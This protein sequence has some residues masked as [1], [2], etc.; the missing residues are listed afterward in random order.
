MDY[1]S[2]KR[3]IDAKRK[4]LGII[5]DEKNINKKYAVK[6]SNKFLNK[7]AKEDMLSKD[8]MEIPKQAQSRESILIDKAFK[9]W[10]D[11][12][13]TISPA[14]IAKDLGINAVTLFKTIENANCSKAL[15]NSIRKK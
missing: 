2:V 12:K 9:I 7:Y 11:S 15:W 3:R 8:E 6:P 10:F 4:E 14:T 13:C 5:V 1:I